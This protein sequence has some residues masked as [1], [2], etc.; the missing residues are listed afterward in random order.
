M[1]DVRLL[2]PVI[3]YRPGVGESIADF[4]LNTR[5]VARKVPKSVILVELCTKEDL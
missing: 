5:T 3:W 1:A 2:P 4:R